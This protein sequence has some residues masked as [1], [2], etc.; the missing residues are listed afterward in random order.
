MTD[1]AAEAAFAKWLEEHPPRSA[2]IHRA[3]VEAFALG[4]RAG[5]EEC[6][7]ALVAVTHENAAGVIRRTILARQAP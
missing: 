3:F 7:E 5:A 6:V 4:R 2:S 1:P